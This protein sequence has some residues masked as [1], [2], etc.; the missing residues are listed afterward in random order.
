MP[1]AFMCDLLFQSVFMKNLEIQHTNLSLLEL[2]TAT[3]Y[4]SRGPVSLYSTEM[5]GSTLRTVW[6]AQIQTISKLSLTDLQ[7]IQA[8][9]SREGGGN[10][11]RVFHL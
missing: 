10:I 7:L 11:S 2:Q 5:W 3:R 6:P 9:H 4:S 1:G 8:V